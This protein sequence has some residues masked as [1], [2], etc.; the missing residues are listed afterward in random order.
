ME[1]RL[2]FSK[3]ISSCIKH[4]NIVKITFNRS[5]VNPITVI[6]LM[7]LKRVLFLV[8]KNTGK[9]FKLIDKSM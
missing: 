5:V 6:L 3:A 8:I 2:Q 7:A 4:V 9:M 1:L